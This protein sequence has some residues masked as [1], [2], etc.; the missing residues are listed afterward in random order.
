[1]KVVG[2]PIEVISYTDDKGDIRPLRFRLKIE[3][4]TVKVIKVDKVIVKETEKLAGNI[5]FIFKCQSLIDNVLKLF[6]IKY[7][8]KTCKWMLYKI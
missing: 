8:L 1:M 7:D 3:D 2:K 4:D 5:M 6:E